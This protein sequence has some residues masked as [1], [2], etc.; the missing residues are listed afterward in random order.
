MD[1]FGLLRQLLVSCMYS[2]LGCCYS[3]KTI[4]VAPSVSG[5]WTACF[6]VVCVPQLLQP[7]H[8][9]LHTFIEARIDLYLASSRFLRCAHPPCYWV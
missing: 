1:V 3:G 5:T 7:L 9:M 4:D 8:V 6:I 2:S